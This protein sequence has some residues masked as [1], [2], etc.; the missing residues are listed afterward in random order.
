MKWK[1]RCLLVWRGDVSY[2][3]IYFNSKC[4]FLL[5]NL[6]SLLY[7]ILLLQSQYLS[8]GCSHPVT[9]NGGH[10]DDVF[11]VLRNKCIL[12]LNGES[13]DDSFTVRSF[14]AAVIADDGSLL[15]PELGEQ[16]ETIPHLHLRFIH[17]L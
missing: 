12:D 5:F 6:T 13:D 3:V 16:N 11:D 8:D 2:D 15:D 7:H 1:R 10:G 17:G 9:V 14:I 4:F